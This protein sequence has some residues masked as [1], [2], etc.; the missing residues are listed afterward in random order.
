MGEDTVEVNDWRNQE[1]R[2]GAERLEKEHS[3]QSWADTKEMRCRLGGKVDLGTECIVACSVV[4]VL[5]F[6]CLM[7]GLHFQCGCLDY[8]VYLCYAL[9]KLV[10]MLFCKFT[11]QYMNCFLIQVNDVVG[12]TRKHSNITVII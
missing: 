2:E 9:I 12:K 6:F 5:L 4:V 1:S 3:E 11:L 10:H 7:N 8:T